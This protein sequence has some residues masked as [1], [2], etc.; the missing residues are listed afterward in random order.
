MS[1]IA[2]ADPRTALLRTGLALAAFLAVFD[3]VGGAINLVGPDAFAIA[4]SIVMI[5]LA[6]LTL[7]LVVVAWRGSRGS[8]IAVATIR[9]LASLAGLPAFF[10][11]ELPAFLVVI[12]ASGI[13]LAIGAAVLILAGLGRR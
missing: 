11:P 12:A 1:T 13:V 4:I 5:V 8:A 10:F 3:I 9:V 7:A 2:S 6:V